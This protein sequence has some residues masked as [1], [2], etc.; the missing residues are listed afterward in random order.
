MV[1]PAGCDPW[2]P[3]CELCCVAAGAA[4]AAGCGACCACSGIMASPMTKTVNVCLST[5]HLL[6]LRWPVSVPR[7]L[8]PRMS[9]CLIEQ[10]DDF[11]IALGACN[12]QRRLTALRP[13]QHV[14][15]GVHQ[16]LDHLGAAVG[17]GDRQRSDAAAVA[18]VDV[19][20]LLDERLRQ[21][22]VVIR[23]GKH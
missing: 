4:A 10:P 14:C 17:G 6:P 23:G 5:T 12:G 1:L 11:L 22:L 15:A 2:A 9:R 3:G 19:G 16:Q 7:S 20:A 8:C 18:S 21:R 13:R